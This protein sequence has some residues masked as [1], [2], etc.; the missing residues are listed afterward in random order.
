MP[1]LWPWLLFGPYSVDRGWREVQLSPL[2]NATS[3][4]ASV[5]RS[6]IKKEAACSK[7]K[8]RD[9][10]DIVDCTLGERGVSV[11]N[12]LEARKVTASETK[13]KLGFDLQHLQ[14]IIAQ[15]ESKKTR[16]ES[17]QASYLLPF[18]TDEEKRGNYYE[19]QSLL[20]ELKQLEEEIEDMKKTKTKDNDVEVLPPPSKLKGPTQ[21][22][23]ASCTSTPLLTKKEKKPSSSQSPSDRPNW[24][25]SNVEVVKMFPCIIYIFFYSPMM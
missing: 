6:K 13:N 11:S 12:Q 16:L 22:Q 9:H 20:G 5:S 7:D 23:S 21:R 15:R 17:C 25:A 10:N 19:A 24:M 2:D 8:A 14:L 18:L 3:N 4:V 1:Y